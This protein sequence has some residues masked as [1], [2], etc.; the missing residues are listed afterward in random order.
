MRENGIQSF[1]CLPFHS[2]VHLLL[3]L[4]KKNQKKKNPIH[5][6]PLTPSTRNFNFLK[7]SKLHQT[8]VTVQSILSVCVPS[9]TKSHFSVRF[10][11]DASPLN[12]P[13]PPRDGLGA[14]FPTNPSM[15]PGQHF[16]CCTII[17][18]MS[19]FSFRPLG[20]PRAENLGLHSSSALTSSA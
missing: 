5:K 20:E 10:H 4:K 14:L 9:L 17:T 19:L 2:P 18:S 13:K 12:S 8:R 7:L 11:L 16:P 3:V 6:T 15:P 1:L